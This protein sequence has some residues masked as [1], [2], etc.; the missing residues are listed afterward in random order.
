MDLNTKGG[1][2]LKDRWL[3]WKWEGVDSE[4]GISQRETCWQVA[5]GTDPIYLEVRRGG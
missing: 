5:P 2:Q 1:D 4:Q 3:P